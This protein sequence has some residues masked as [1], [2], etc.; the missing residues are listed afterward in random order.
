MLQDP[1]SRVS[2]RTA[3]VVEDEEPMRSILKCM[4]E[5]LGFEVLV[6]CDGMQ[7][8]KMHETRQPEL[9]LVISDFGMP[10]ID[11]VETLATL[12]KTS[13]GFKAILC[14]GTPEADCLQGRS[15]EAYVYLGKPFR[16]QELNAAVEQVL[17]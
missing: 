10:G 1:A 7:A 6:A 13:P 16:F 3:L 4:L 5:I 11:G 2:P 12:R 9:D 17:A 8:V 15:L 14:S